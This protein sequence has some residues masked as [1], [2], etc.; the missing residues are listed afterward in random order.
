MVM[1][2]PFL[3]I[4]LST[5]F[6]SPRRSIHMYFLGSVSVIDDWHILRKPDDFVFALLSRM[7]SIALGTIKI[8]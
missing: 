7:T 4:V 8:L 2:C 6:V 1:F 3:R 5:K